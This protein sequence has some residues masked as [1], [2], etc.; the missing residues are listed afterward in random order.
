MIVVRNALLLFMVLFGW[1]R[2]PSAYAQILTT[3]M[4]LSMTVDNS[5]PEVGETV[6][7]TLAVDRK[8]VV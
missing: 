3:D 5:T 8:S 1:V 2:I 6:T 4:Q 7:F